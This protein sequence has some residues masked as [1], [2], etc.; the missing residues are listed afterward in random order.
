ML[1]EEEVIRM[2]ENGKLETVIIRVL[3]SKRAVRQSLFFR[4][5]CEGDFSALGDGT[6]AS[7]G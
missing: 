7:Q 4:M 5:I 1:M 2:Q 3:R 6:N